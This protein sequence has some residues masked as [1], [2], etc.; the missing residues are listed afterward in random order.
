MCEQNMTALMEKLGV[1]E[2]ILW[3]GC[4]RVVGAE[5]E[6]VSG[7]RG[8]LGFCANPFVCRSNIPLH[9]HVSVS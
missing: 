9:G 5:A 6:A 7:P 1:L 8:A 3:P 2:A 4:S